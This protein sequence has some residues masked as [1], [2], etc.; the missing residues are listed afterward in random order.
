VAADTKD[1]G[2]VAEVFHTMYMPYQQMLLA[3]A[4]VV[5]VSGD[6][7]AIAPAVRA[8][9]LAHDSNQA[10]DNVMTI[11][12]LSSESVA[13]QRLNALLLGGFA[14]L[15]L[16]IAAVGIGGVLAFSV[17]SRTREFGVRCALG[18]RRQQVWSGVVTGRSD[19]GRTRRLPRDRRRCGHDAL[20]FG[21]TGRSSGAGSR[22]VPRGGPAAGWRRDHRAAWVPAWRAASVTPME[23]LAAE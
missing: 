3:G 14:V 22:D 6:P 17:G 5:R 8:A 18:A 20:H 11:A 13:P 2:L 16:V 10:I 7:V 4:L 21:S 1:G 19:A 15:A 23:A 12:A 9:I